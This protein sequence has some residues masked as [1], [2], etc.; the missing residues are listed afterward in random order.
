MVNETTW[1]VTEKASVVITLATGVLLAVL[2]WASFHNTWVLWLA[3]SVGGL[4]GLVH[5]IAQ[6]GGEIAFFEKKADGFYLGSLAGVVLGAVAGMLVVRGHLPSVTETALSISKTQ[7]AYEVFTAGL[8]LK[9]VTE[10]ASGTAV[11]EK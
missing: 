11:N 1:T 2:A 10:A 6:S 8:A 5:E 9:G 3:V 7:L 4:G